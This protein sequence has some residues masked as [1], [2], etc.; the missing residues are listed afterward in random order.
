MT[1]VKYEC[2]IK[3]VASVLIIVKNW[4]NSG[5]EKIGLVTPTPEQAVDHALKWS[6]KLD[7]IMPTLRYI[8]VVKKREKWSHLQGFIDKPVVD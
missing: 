1:P 6:V 2:G 5:T 7:P 8:N 3:Q 4:E